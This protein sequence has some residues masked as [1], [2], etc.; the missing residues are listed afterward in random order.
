MPSTD[1]TRFL[2]QMAMNIFLSNYAKKKLAKINTR[3]QGRQTLKSYLTFLLFSVLIIG[4][5]QAVYFFFKPANLY[6]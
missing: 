4:L 6:E 3:K 1:S 5:N 2:V